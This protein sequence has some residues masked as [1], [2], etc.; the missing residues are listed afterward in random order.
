MVGGSSLVGWGSKNSQCMCKTYWLLGTCVV[1]VGYGCGVWE[2]LVHGDAMEA[3]RC[4][5]VLVCA[6]DTLIVG[7]L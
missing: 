4:W 5:C 1:D 6:C 2:L 3:F 7:C